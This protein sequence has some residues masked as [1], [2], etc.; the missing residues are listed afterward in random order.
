[1]VWYAADQSNQVK[2]K[3]EEKNHFFNTSKMFKFYTSKSSAQRRKPLRVNK[4][5]NA[6][7]AND[8]SKKEAVVEEASNCID[9]SL[10]SR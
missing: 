2:K 7:S 4:A 6:N 9:E 10:Q 8:V 1:M 3:E 5:L